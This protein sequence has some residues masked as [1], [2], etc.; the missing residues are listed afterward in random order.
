MT[1]E[2]AAVTI[3]IG[4]LTACSSARATNT[5]VNGSPTAP[6]TTSSPPPSQSP[7]VSPSPRPLPHWF[8]GTVSI[9]PADLATQMRGTTWHPGCPVPISDLRLLSLRYWGFDGQVHEGPMV[10]NE[11][12]ASDVVSV[13]RTLFQARFPIKIMHL[14]V[15]YVPNQDD[16]NDKRDYTAGFNCRPVVT[17]L[18]PKGF[19]SQHSYGW[20]IDINPIENPYVTSTGYVHNNNARPYRNRAVQRPGMIHPGDVVVQAFANIGWGWGGYW[21]GDKDYMHF[22]LTGR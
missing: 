7:S 16:P 6:P 14:A 8:K 3:V 4:M 21:S 2:A 13:F 22:S 11:R 15:K 9:I 17:A 12:V 18:G 5:Q 20:A 1:W 19:F 10:V